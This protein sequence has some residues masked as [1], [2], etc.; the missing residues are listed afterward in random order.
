M[1]IAVDIDDYDEIPKE[2][3][4]GDSYKYNCHIDSS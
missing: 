4:T 2:D 1:G 3:P